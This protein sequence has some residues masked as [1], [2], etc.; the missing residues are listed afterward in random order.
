[1]KYKPLLLVLLVLVTIILQL[2]IEGSF[3]FLSGKVNLVLIVMILLVNLENFD[4]VAWFAV[5]AGLLL[6]IYSATPFGTMSLSLFFSAVVCSVLFNNFFT[7]F[8]FYSVMI[9]GLISIIAY[10]LIFFVIS[11][12]LFFFGLSDF[13]PQLDYL[14]R[15][16]WQVVVTELM[17]AV[18]YYLV[19]IFSGK[20][21]PMF[22][23]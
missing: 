16:I 5:G 14:Y 20:F 21:R 23:R 17:M 13:F 9:L 11:A 19:N 22:I 2:A 4:A 10:H 18:A 3:N 15:V 1:M 7:N 8:S 12:G 6:D